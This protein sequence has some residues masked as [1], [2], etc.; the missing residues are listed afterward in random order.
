MW[1]AIQDPRYVANPATGSRHNRGAAIDLTLLGPDGTELLMPSEFDDFSER[2][3]R[4][5]MACEPAARENRAHLEQLM[6]SAGFTGLAT[7]WWHFDW[8]GWEAAPLRE[9]SLAQ[10]KEQI[11]GG[12]RGVPPL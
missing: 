6:E 1:E 7:E 8:R 4:N 3:H 10:V 2:A 9:E 11:R 5:F 12:S